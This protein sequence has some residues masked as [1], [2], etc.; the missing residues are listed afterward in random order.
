[1]RQR[2]RPAY[3]EYK[4]RELYGKRYYH[5]FWPD[6]R[7]RVQETIRF[8]ELLTLPGDGVASLADLSA[9]DGAISLAAKLRGADGAKH[10]GDITPGF[11]YCGLIEK[12]I[13]Q[14]PHVELF[15]CTETI[16][17]LDNPDQLL[18]E[19][20]FKADTLVLSTPL[21]ES[22]TSNNP[23]HYWRWDVQGV[24]EM[25]SESGWTPAVQRNIHY[26]GDL[27]HASADYQLWGCR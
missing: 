17:H 25:L 11:E 9:G 27:E 8:I 7:L 22:E 19:I 3:D 15:I 24:E 6:H 26:P 16:E 4:L 10:L 2:L 13:W 18:S 23:E 21:N 14:I 5:A 1:M 12:T 20:R